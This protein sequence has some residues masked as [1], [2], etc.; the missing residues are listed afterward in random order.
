[1]VSSARK[2]FPFLRKLCC[3]LLFPKS[4]HSF[5]SLLFSFCLIEQSNLKYTC[6]Q[7]FLPSSSKWHIHVQ[8]LCRK[9]E[10]YFSERYHM[11][12]FYCSG[13]GRFTTWL[14]VNYMSAATDPGKDQVC[15]TSTSQ[16]LDE[17]SILKD[18]KGQNQTLSAVLWPLLALSGDPRVNGLQN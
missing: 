4:K 8:C 14:T 12:P 7:C 9:R 18:R 5:S 15:Q 2:Q 13:L 11:T 6:F 17:G 16:W 10:W 1:M 3:W